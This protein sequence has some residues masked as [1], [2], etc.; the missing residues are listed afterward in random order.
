MEYM[1]CPE[2]AKKWGVSERWV[3][4][5]CE[6]NRILNVSRIGNM[7]LIPMNAE[8]PLDRRLKQTKN[9]VERNG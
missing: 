3:Q 8:K 5:L 1:S 6:D 7:W 2:V 9:G 4:K